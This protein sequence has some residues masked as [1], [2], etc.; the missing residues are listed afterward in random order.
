[1]KFAREVQSEKSGERCLVVTFLPVAVQRAGSGD[2]L[3]A[4]DLGVT[5]LEI[6]EMLELFGDVVIPAVRGHSAT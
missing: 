2:A 4:P 3:G 5:A 1:M 6:L